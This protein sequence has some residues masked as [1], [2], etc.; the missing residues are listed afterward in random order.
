MLIAASLVWTPKAEKEA[1]QYLI[2]PPPKL[3]YFSFGYQMAIADQLWIRSIQ[4]FDY[5]ENLI[6]KN[7]CEGNGWLADMLDTLTSLAPDYLIAYKAGGLALTVIVS[8]YPG[9]SRI[10][11][12]GVAIFPKDL[13]L[14]YRAA[15]HAMIEE[16]NNEK[17]A[18][19]FVQAAQNG[20][21]AWFYSLATRLLTEAGKQE[22]A[23][24]LYHELEG[25]DIEPGTL[26]RIRGKLGLSIKSQT[27]DSKEIKGKE[28]DEML[29][30]SG[31]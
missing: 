15:Y 23:M 6:A 5:C 20:G 8:D 14:L 24:N 18:R 30:S 9:A 31:E 2:S 26:E 16:K 12:K 29:D 19:I 21:N 25:T 3:E 11:D 1:K 4:D 27:K 10:F 17:A 28:S 13:N 7:H 22:A